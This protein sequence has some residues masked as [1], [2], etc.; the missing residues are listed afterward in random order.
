MTPQKSHQLLMNKHQALTQIIDKL[1]R[2]AYVSQ[3]C[4]WSILL[5]LKYLHIE[6]LN[7]VATI[8]FALLL[9]SQMKN[10]NLRRKLDQD[11]THITL[12][13]IAL[14]KH[15]PRL[16]SF[17]HD[18]LRDFGIFRIML[19]RALLDLGILFF[20]SFSVLQLILEMKPDFEI[21]S[22]LLYPLVG[23]LGFFF[24]DL[25]YEPLKPL[26]NAKRESLP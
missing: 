25:Y 2:S 16:E 5:F 6:Q 24:G 22:W 10:F 15:N 13:G 23:I 21:N 8:L 26:V 19:Q 20:F 11:M 14:E 4:V 3:I 9:L 18:V 7:L 17:F 1:K 12:E